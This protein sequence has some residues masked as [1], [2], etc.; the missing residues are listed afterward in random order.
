M[1]PVNL[2]G[3]EASPGSRQ[4][5]ESV[6]DKLLTTFGLARERPHPGQLQVRQAAKV[7]KQRIS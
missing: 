4:I 6:N 5:R 1:S 2:Q 7:A 3:P